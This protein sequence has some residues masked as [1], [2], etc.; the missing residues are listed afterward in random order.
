MQENR[1]IPPAL[2]GTTMMT[3]FSYLVSEAHNKNFI[4]P[5]LIAE[6]IKRLPVKMNDSTA[7]TAGWAMHYG[8]GFAWAPVLYGLLKKMPA[9]NTLMASLAVGAISGVTAV[10]VWKAAFSVHPAAPDTDYKRFY[11]QLVIAHW[12]FCLP[13]VLRYKDQR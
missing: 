4:E 1:N 10:L 3:A 7:R 9:A 6:M 8:V 2:T 11:R 12:I 13:F 5:E